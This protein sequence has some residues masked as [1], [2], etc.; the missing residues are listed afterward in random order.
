MSCTSPKARSTTT[1]ESKGDLLEAL[2]DRMR[3]DVEPIMLPIIDDPNLPTLDKL[4]RFFDVVRPLEDGA[5]GLS[6]LAAARLVRRRK[7]H[8]APKIHG[9]CDP[10]V[11]AAARR[12]DP[13]G[14]SGRRL[15]HRVSRSDRPKSSSACCKAWGRRSKIALLAANPTREK[16]QRATAW[17]RPTTM[18]WNACWARRL[19]R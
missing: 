10:V 17:W 5:Q 16:M 14:C 9:Q 4:H 7:C 12:S 2:I 18:R 11:R 1:F 8:R 3:L 19:A 15:A 6:A 13:A